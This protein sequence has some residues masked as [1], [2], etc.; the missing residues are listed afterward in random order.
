M[1]MRKFRGR[2]L[3]LTFLL[4][5][6]LFTLMLPTQIL[7]IVRI[8]CLQPMIQVEAIADDPQSH[9]AVSSSSRTVRCTPSRFVQEK[10]SGVFQ[11]TTSIL[12]HRQ[13]PVLKHED[14]NTPRGLIHVARSSYSAY[15]FS[16]WRRFPGKRHTLIS[17]TLSRLGCPPETPSSPRPLPW[18]AG[19][20]L[21]TTEMSVPVCRSEFLSCSFRLLF[22]K[23][24]PPEAAQERRRHC[25]PN[26]P[27]PDERAHAAA[28]RRQERAC[29]DHGR[30]SPRFLGGYGRA[31]LSAFPLAV[32][33]ASWFASSM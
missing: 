32:F 16:L 29:A 1:A 9:F 11:I 10:K 33:H 19:R 15:S 22:L 12:R 2:F 8:A 14:E 20:R 3:R 17:R 21:S 5:S 25:I 13:T 18:E 31:L 4:F 27:V 6:R 26:R 24:I 28:P 7:P 30:I 23:S